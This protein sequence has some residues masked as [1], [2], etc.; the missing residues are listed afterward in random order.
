[1]KTFNY[2]KIFLLGLGFFSISLVWQLYDFYVPLFLRTYIDSQFKI[3][4]IMTFDNILA[5][6][7]IP[8][9]AALSDR[10]N[11]KLGRRMPYLII[12]IP[13]SAVFFTLLPHFNS[14]IYLIAVIFFLN[15]SMAIYR[16][17]TIALMP[18]ITPENERSKA[19]G[20]INFM[21]GLASVL[22]FSIG[23]VLYE[24]S[25]SL[26][27]LIASV[28]IVVSLILLYF[29]IK[30]P[31][32]GSIAREDKISIIHSLKEIKNSGNYNSF[33]ILGAIFTWFLGYQGVL[34]TFSNYTVLYLG[35]SVKIGTFIILFFALFFL[36]FA[37]PSGYI[38]T[39]LGKKKTIQFGL[40]ALII[41]FLIL[42]F[43]R[44]DFSLFGL[45]YNHAMMFFF[46]TGGIGWALINI[47]S[48]PLIISQA[49]EEEIGTYTGLYYFAS[50][51]AAIIGPLIM[52]FF[53][54]L[55]GF[56]TMFFLAVISFIISY[57]LIK[58]IN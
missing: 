10:T 20:I 46:A 54:D 53:V 6:S 29:F 37:I 5:V 3:N 50:S 2:R 12:G 56:G 31:V 13:L 36:I 14:F 32:K 17:P 19:N 58:K 44:T 11:S 26:P 52:G 41:S 1:M 48:Y 33:Y 34:A 25:K 18:D 21:G 51:L 57:I 22:V 28:L 4:T 45:N 9:F 27:F 49:P 16:A 55:L 43:I 24:K 47:N 7:L 40:I 35:A 23:A 39:K 38:G 8:Y 42:S 30:E 15:L